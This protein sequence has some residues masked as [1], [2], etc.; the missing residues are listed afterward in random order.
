VAFGS[1]ESYLQG[2][3]LTYLPTDAYDAYV[4]ATGAVYDNSTGLLEITQA[5]Y[6]ALEPLV[7]NIG[8]AGSF[9]LLPNAQIW[10]RALNTAIGGSAS[11]IYLVIA[12]VSPGGNNGKQQLNT[13][14]A[15]RRGVHK[16]S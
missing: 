16:R 11:A 2:T 13:S 5:Q 14:H 7:F 4:A 9:V 8:S 1:S 3:T 15:G 6:D 10:P 12:D